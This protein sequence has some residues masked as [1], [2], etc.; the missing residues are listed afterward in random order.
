[1]AYDGI[2]LK[3]ITKELNENIINT[4][5]E[6]IYQPTKESI[7]L[8]MRSNGEKKKLL[9]DV[10]S[11]APRIH[12]TEGD[13]ENPKT[14]PTF[15]MLLRKHLEN[16]KFLGFSQIGMDRILKI[17]ILSKDEL[18]YEIKKSLIIEIMG[19]Y[20]NIIL[21]E[22]ETNKIIDSIKRVNKNMSS[23]R[24]ILP[25]LTYSCDAISKK[26]DPLLPNSFSKV[27]INA[28]TI[29]KSLLETFMGF[30]PLIIREICNQAFIDEDRPINSLSSEE[31]NS[32]KNSFDEIVSKIK[33]NEFFPILIE[34]NNK[35][36]D[37]SAIDL[38]LYSKNNKTYFSSISSMVDY[39]YSKKLSTQIVADKSS[40]LKKNI[41]NLISREEN[42]LQKQLKEFDSS[43]NRDKYK[44]YGDLISSNIYRI[45]AGQENVALENFYDNMNPI[46]IPLDIKLSPQANA[47]KYYKK[48]AKLKNAFNV[49]TTEIE[50]TK[51]S[52]DYLK[53]ILFSIDISESS[54]DIDEI[55]EELYEMHYL[56]KHNPKK[57]KTKLKF[58]EYI[59]ADGHKIYC[60]KNNKQ[61]D[62]LTLKFANNN[63]L[64]FHVQG[65]P[66]SHV[67][68]K[69]SEKEFTEESINTA[70]KIAADNSSLK[71]SNNI[72]VDYVLKK[73][74]K[75][76]PSKIPGLV[77]YTDFQTLIVKK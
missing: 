64:W 47:N 18:A 44:I 26:C 24:E 42:K 34:D 19:K 75:R 49:L 72:P 53:S 59:T 31:L 62:Y 51:K 8:Q 12:F 36:I 61:N 21:V 9:I 25:G 23:V 35:L 28:N 13:F 15:C 10:S 52:I 71:S 32:L 1:M 65:A 58:L 43:K 74:V 17:D 5:I 29:R 41:K 60:G 45:E 50:N 7:I 16:F 56:K 67:I 70:A 33:L 2:V 38:T 73:Y 63:D 69:S 77:L 30:S 27:D 22:S 40:E 55:K 68:L 20:S 37:F 39:F 4:K 48:F 3:A 14:P 46:V 11:Q 66:G 54:D 76:H 6:K 57:S